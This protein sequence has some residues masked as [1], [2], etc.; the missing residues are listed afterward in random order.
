M[1]VC[2]EICLNKWEYRVTH[3]SFHGEMFL[4]FF[5]FFSEVGVAR[6]EGKYEGLVDE[7]SWGE[8]L[9]SRLGNSAW[10]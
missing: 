2:K 4:L 9:G 8:Q 1:N 10:L 3:R 5:V 6:A 7:W